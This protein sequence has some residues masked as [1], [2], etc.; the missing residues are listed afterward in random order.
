MRKQNIKERHNKI[1]KFILMLR[2]DEVGIELHI[3]TPNLGKVMERNP[4]N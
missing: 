2:H 4:M 3:Y 1:N